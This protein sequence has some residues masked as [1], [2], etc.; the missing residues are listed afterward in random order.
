MMG[1]KTWKPFKLLV[2]RARS[3]HQDGSTFE[4]AG[5]K[6]REGLIS[7]VQG[8]AG[9]L[10]DDSHFRRQA[11]E[12][13][14]ILSC[15]IGNRYE[16]SLTEREGKARIGNHRRRE[17]TIACIPGEDRMIAQIFLAVG[18]IGADSAGMTEPRYPDALTH[19]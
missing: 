17:A 13:D 6:I 11:Q 16:L 19:S 12:I 5:A 1:H 3:W 2:A 8:I 15:E 18:A 7:L 4:S 14:A 10:G 9:R